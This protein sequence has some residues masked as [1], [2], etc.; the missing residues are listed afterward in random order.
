[1][2]YLYSVHTLMSMI[3]IQTKIHDKF[4]LEFK[5]SYKAGKQRVVYDFGLNTWVFIPHSLD[6]NPRTYTRED[7]YKDLHTNVRLITPVY[8]LRDIIS[9]EKSP[10]VKLQHAM[11]QMASEPTEPNIAEY[12][13][14]IKM[15]S[16]IYKSAIRDQLAYIRKSGIALNKTHLLEKY[17]DEIED[18][19]K[20]YRGL[21]T[22]IR[23][24][25]VVQ[26]NY[27]YYIF[28]DEFMLNLTEKELFSFLEKMK[29]PE[30]SDIY[31][32]VNKLIC[33]FIEKEKSYKVSQ[34][35]EMIDPD[36]SA[37]NSDLIFRFGALKKYIESDLFLN[38]RKKREGVIA[39]QVY[40]SLAAGLSMVF[41]TTVA[42]SF[43][44]TYG[45]FTMPLFVAL[46]VSYMLKDRIKELMRYYFAHTRSRK[47]YDHK[48]TFSIK[49][50][51]IG[52]SKE[53]FDFIPEVKIPAK[54]LATRNRLPLI[55]ADSRH[56][57]EKI[58]LFKKLIRIDR[59]QLET[60]SDYNIDGVV[61][62][63]RLNLSSFM[64]K[65]DNPEVPLY[66][67]NDENQVKQIMG[68]KIYYL[69]IV[70]QYAPDSEEQLI[71]FR[72]GFNREGIKTIHKM[73]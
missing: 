37:L 69:N 53:G 67:L 22:I 1:M 50:G 29:S 19:L 40:F 24:H 68:T 3:N 17:L 12:E 56:S 23:T 33:R 4:T 55:Q 30:F 58:F 27:N 18:I 16:A 66:I 72:I 21:A 42:F 60:T 46:V 51:E 11:S 28:G 63:V 73:N 13:Y 38:A 35:Y 9:G 26:E 71:R 32:E 45:N 59:K 41:A 61:E 44:Q 2:P 39:E 43:Q 70:L 52:W 31:E 15:F 47:Y 7:F 10:L 20:K 14:Q 48:T 57:Q 5:I 8:L 6:V 34:G 36:N 54:V 49:Q 64:K 62:I 25:T 65:M